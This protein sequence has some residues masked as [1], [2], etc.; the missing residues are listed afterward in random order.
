MEAPGSR[1]KPKYKIGVKVKRLD[2]AAKDQE[3]VITDRYWDKDAKVLIVGTSRK[4]K[5]WWK[6]VFG[7]NKA[8]DR[9]DEAKDATDKAE[10][11][12]TENELE[13]ISPEAGSELKGD[14][15]VEQ[16]PSDTSG[17]TEP[18]CLP[19]QTGKNELLTHKRTVIIRPEGYPRL[20]TRIGSDEKFMLYRRFGYLQSRILLHRQDELRELEDKLARSDLAA[21][22]RDPVLLQSREEGSV[23]NKEHTKLLNTI[24]EKYKA[25]GWCQLR[26]RGAKVLISWLAELMIISQNLANL[27]GPQKRDYKSVLDYFVEEQ[28]LC[29][30]DCYIEEESDIVTLKPGRETTWLDMT[31]EALL[32]KTEC[33]LTRKIRLNVDP[34]S[35]KNDRLDP[36]RVDILVAVIILTMIITLLTVP[37]YIL[38]Y[39]SRSSSSNSGAIIGSIIGVLTVFTLIFTAV[40]TLCTRAKRHEVLASAAAYV[41]LFSGSCEKH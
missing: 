27:E 32:H 35:S 22:K 37:V 12:V 36:K 1:P 15:T 41:T 6:Y 11:G 34:K 10:D 18:L 40:L 38:W 28:P 5:G 16:K 39:L 31:V 2:D 20:A 17:G 8:K 21:A 3:M 14:D 29:I 19:S 33:G 26:C 24:E 30:Q 9:I 7:T 23:L 25:Y 4:K 13:T